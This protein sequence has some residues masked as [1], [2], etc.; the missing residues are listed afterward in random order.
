MNYSRMIMLTMV[1]LSVGFVSHA[2]AEDAESPSTSGSA[3]AQTSSPVQTLAPEKLVSDKF[4]SGIGIGVL[5]VQSNAEFAMGIQHW[6]GGFGLELNVW[7]LDDSGNSDWGAILDTEYRFLSL[8]ASRWF[9]F[10]VFGVIGGGYR[11][12]MGTYSDNANLYTDGSYQSNW[13]G[14]AGFGIEPILWQHIGIP[15]IFTYM[16]TFPNFSLAPELRLELRVDF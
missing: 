1:M 9:S 6:F 5:G 4:P 10:N 8:D 15:L 13:L 7:A 16:A 3:S 2:F 12:A 11:A 14:E